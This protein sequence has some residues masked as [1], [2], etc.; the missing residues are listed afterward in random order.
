MTLTARQSTYLPTLDGWRAVAIVA[1]MAS[2]SRHLTEAG[3]PFPSY[4][5]ERALGSL[6]LGVDLFFAI[7]GFLITRLL[8][9]ENARTGTVSLRAFYLRRAF[10][11]LPVI[12]VYML[13]LALLSL[14]LPGL[15]A[16]WE[17]PATI[18]FARNYLMH[19]PANAATPHFW[20]LSVEEHF[21]L[22]WP[23]LLAL[24]GS[25]KALRFAIFGVVAVAVWRATDS[26][27][28]L[29]RL[30]F[31]GDA[32]VLFRS[33]TRFDALLAG[34]IAALAL[35]HAQTFFDRVRSLPVT[36][37]IFAV[38]VV[39]HAF[40]V[41]A[42]PSLLV[43]LFPLLILSTICRKSSFASRWLEARPLRWLGQLSYSLYVWHTLFLTVPETSF[44]R[45]AYGSSPLRLAGAY[46]IDLALAFVCAIVSN[47]V[48]EGPLRRKGRE[49]AEAGA[50]A[51]ASEA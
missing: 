13:V 8:V 47:R 17:F 30:V 16:P 20:S 25:K 42:A 24:V 45:R 48:V 35:D 36:A 51:R 31:G 44:S 38:L 6:R 14:W 37:G 10:R 26:R 34:A 5:L 19:W 2:H 12:I 22:L 1:V 50:A 27:Y 18:F 4:A 46:L 40:H 11:I 32:G 9:Q 28:H 7:S 39:I 21:Y 41:P 23:P 49:L 29:F 3:G 33:D 43:F 15:V